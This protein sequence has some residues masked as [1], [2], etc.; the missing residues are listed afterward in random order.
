VN[1]GDLHRRLLAESLAER[2]GVALLAGDAA[3]AERVVRE[4][5]DEELPYALI[6]AGVITPA[7]RR[8][9]TLWERGEISVAHEHMA[10]QITLRVLA[11]L[12]ELHRV[13]E[14]RADQR[15]MLAAVEGEQHIVGLQMAADLLAGAGY[16]VVLLGPDVPSAALEDIVVE[17]RPAIVG[18][19]V[20]MP[21]ALAALPA[22]IDAAGAGDPP[23][24]VMIGGLGRPPRLPGTAGV[25]WVDSVV[26]AVDTADRL[27][28][29]PELN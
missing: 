16:D 3:A 26:E 8:I 19:T 29:R 12:R 6:Q 10:T 13:T 25:E 7:L 15:A 9:G 28:R 24:G 4:A 21:A 20:T 11:M 1:D 27:V 22:A 5:H 23:A 18:L 14:Q 2:Y 17:H